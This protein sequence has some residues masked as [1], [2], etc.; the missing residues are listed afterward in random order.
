MR[1]LSAILMAVSLGA[2]AQAVYKHV[3]KD[4]KIYYSDKPPAK[5]APGKKLD[6][7]SKRNVIPPLATKPSEKGSDPNLER[8]DKRLEKQDRLLAELEGAK[9]RL[10]AAK[11]ALDAGLEPQEDEWVTAIGANKTARRV[12]NDLY[13]ARVKDL[14]EAV[15]KAEADLSKAEAA[16]RR[17]VSN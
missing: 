2:S 16:H 1:M 15:K 14:E 10:A 7:D 3:D 6:V 5:D 17:G 4:G 13:H 9:E 12:P 11:E 8:F